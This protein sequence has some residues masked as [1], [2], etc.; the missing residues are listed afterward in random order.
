MA[1]QSTFDA[2]YLPRSTQ[3]QPSVPIHLAPPLISECPPAIV[4]SMSLGYLHVIRY[5]VQV[6]QTASRGGNSP[7]PSTSAGPSLSKSSPQWA[8]S[9]WCPIQSSNWPPPML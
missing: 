5:L 1:N 3:T 4:I 7:C 2:S 6:F 9:Q 8:I